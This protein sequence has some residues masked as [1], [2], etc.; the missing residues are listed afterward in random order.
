[1]PFYISH[2]VIN[3]PLVIID[4]VVSLNFFTLSIIDINKNV[5]R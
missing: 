4:M 1:M 5:N 3:I 2:L